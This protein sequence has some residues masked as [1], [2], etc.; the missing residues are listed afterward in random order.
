MGKKNYIDK[1]RLD[2]LVL[3]Y[4]AD[5]DFSSELERSIRLIVDGVMSNWKWGWEKYPSWHR[6][7]CYS[8]A[9][10]QATQAIYKKKWKKRVD[11]DHAFS[12]ITKCVQY[13][14][15][16]QRKRYASKQRAFNK[17]A[18]DVLGADENQE[19]SL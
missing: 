13:A 3:Q 6:D 1:E 7:D 19:N 8:D 10:T 15:L 16:G 14:I 5:G 18:L 11:T 4:Y 12:F 9:Y 2:S 17:Y